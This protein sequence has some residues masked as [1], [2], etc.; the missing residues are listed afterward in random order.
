MI[1][2]Y[3]SNH[4][5]IY[6]YTAQQF[7]VM[8]LHMQQNHYEQTSQY[9]LDLNYKHLLHSHFFLHLFRYTWINSSTDDTS[10]WIPSSVIKPVVKAVKAFF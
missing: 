1:Y 7:L 3:V 4:T 6:T 5:S 8:F 9:C 2:V 10:K